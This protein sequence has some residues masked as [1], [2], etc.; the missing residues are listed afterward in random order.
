MVKQERAARTRETLIRSA[1]EV[2]VRDGF[3]GASLAAI[4]TRAGVSSGALHF[5]FASK[6]ALADAVEESAAQE[7][8]EI[9]AREARAGAGE[10]QHLVDVTHVVGGRLREG[11]VLRAGFG[12]S[13]DVSRTSHTDVRALWH[14]WVQDALRRA[15][16]GGELRAGVTPAAA[17]AA[18]VAATVGFEALGSTDL[19]WLSRATLTQFWLLLLPNLAESAQGAALEAAGCTV[20]H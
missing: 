15:A 4:S 13:S 2:F 3:T 17:T 19:S 12:L 11:A 7:L 10:L 5:H 18:V 16:A 14:A 1:A 9:G 8:R 20:P 6:A